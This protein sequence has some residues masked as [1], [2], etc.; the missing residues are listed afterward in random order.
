MAAFPE[1]LGAAQQDAGGYRVPPVQVQQRVSGESAGP[2]RARGPLPLAEV[3]GELD[4]VRVRVHRGAVHR[5]APISR[6]SAAAATPSTRLTAMLA[7]T[8]PCWRSSAI[9]CVSSIQV[10]KVV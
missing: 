5:W 7:I 10:E 8:L 4:R 3:A 1:S 2:A 9:R 6:P